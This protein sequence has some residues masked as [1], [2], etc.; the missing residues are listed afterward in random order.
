MKSKEDTHNVAE[1]FC[2]LTWDEAKECSEMF[3][4]LWKEDPA[5]EGGPH[6]R[7]FLFH[8]YPQ[9]SFSTL[10]AVLSWEAIT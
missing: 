4:R 7:D 1:S 8:A 6:D 9:S 2:G 10:L 3:E 5:R